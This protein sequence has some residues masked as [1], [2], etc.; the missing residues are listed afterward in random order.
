VD[1]DTDQVL[2]ERFR[3][4]D[5]AAFSE[6]VVRYQRPIYNAAFWLLRNAEDAN[7]IAQVVFLRVAERAEEYNPKYKFFSWI[8]RIAV[9]ES[10]NFL[11]RDGR[12][13]PLDDEVE[14]PGADSANPEWRL[15]EAQQAARIKAALLRLSTN[16]RMV[17]ALRHFS[18]CSYEEIGQILDLDAKTVKSRLFEA[19]HR[20]REL[21]RDLRVN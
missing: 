8:Y 15:G 16:D 3:G 11:R 4:G 10:L 20:L 2:L 21:L 9:N 18:E 6:L 1:N 7:D 13:E 19:R 17:I 5:H 14:L 12:E